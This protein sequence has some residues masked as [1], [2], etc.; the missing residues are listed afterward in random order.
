MLVSANLDC[1]G[2]FSDYDGK[3]AGKLKSL[4]GK[5]V[6]V[7]FKDGKVSAIEPEYLKACILYSR[8]AFS[9]GPKSYL[10]PT[11]RVQV[12]STVDDNSL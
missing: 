6:I 10:T 1:T 12:K 7:M 2:L 3:S 11:G 4:D 9:G 5:P 8:K